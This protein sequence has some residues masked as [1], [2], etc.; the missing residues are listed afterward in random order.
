MAPEGP[1]EAVEGVEAIYA[2]VVWGVMVR[3]VGVAGGRGHAHEAH[4]GEVAVG[5]GVGAHTGGRH[6]VRAQDT[7]PAGPPAPSCTSSWP[8][9]ALHLERK[10]VRQI[11]LRDERA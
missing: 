11:R 3:V 1:R 7:A 2:R 8:Q 10:R 5:M 4:G 6:V 9:V